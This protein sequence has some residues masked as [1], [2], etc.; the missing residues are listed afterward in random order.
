MTTATG[1]GPMPKMLEDA[2]GSRAVA[3]AFEDVGLSLEVIDDRSLRFPLIAMVDLFDRAARLSGDARF[4]LEVGERM[5]P[6]DYGLWARYAVQAPKLGGA[7]DRFR[8]CMIL[9]Q[10]GGALDVSPRPPGHVVW[11][12]RNCLRRGSGAVQHNDH[13]LTVMIQVV[14]AYCGPGW[15]PPWIELGAPN[16]GDAPGRE[17]LT[18]SP[19]MFERGNGVGLAIPSADLS[20]RAR[21]Q[22]GPGPL[23]SSADILAEVRRRRSERA[24][25][26]VAQIVAL[27]LREQETD[28]D[29]AARMAGL[30]RRNLQRLL[31]AE[32]LTYRALLGNVRM[33][34]AEALL[35]ETKMP[36]SQVAQV[37]GYSDQAHF[38]RA[39]R[40]HFGASPSDLRQSRATVPDSCD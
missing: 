13:I 4:G 25:A 32:G 28:I 36:V 21:A 19:W 9:H 20:E 11:E 6:A 30:G 22:T 38:S 7:L 37:L 29:G 35:K 3:R 8:R 34:R 12:Y 24:S 14:R 17:D 40:G 33:A 1:L 39:F 2:A 18:G 23:L 5:V 15:R 31:E 10:V 16:P 27:R 26:H